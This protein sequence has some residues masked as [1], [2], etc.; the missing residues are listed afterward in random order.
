MFPKRFRSCTVLLISVSLLSLGVVNAGAG[1][2][3]FCCAPK[4]ERAAN[5]A[6]SPHEASLL[7]DCCC[8]DGKA[9][10]DF[11]GRSAP[12]LPPSAVSAA[13]IVRVPAPA[14]VAVAAEGPLRSVTSCRSLFFLADLLGTGPPDPLYLQ[15]SSLLC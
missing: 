4:T 10:C 15:H 8:G 2:A 14:G 5:H 12:D 7:H 13:P 3:G 6:G 1:C 11:E 9:P